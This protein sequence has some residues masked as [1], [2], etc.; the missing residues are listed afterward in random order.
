MPALAAASKLGLV[1]PCIQSALQNNVCLAILCAIL[2][3]AQAK[4]YL[5]SKSSTDR[6]M[7]MCKSGKQ[8]IG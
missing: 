5:F 3:S 4:W 6:D 7:C 1:G 2:V 8:A